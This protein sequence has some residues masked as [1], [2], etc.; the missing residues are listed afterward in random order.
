MILVV[1]AGAAAIP[2]FIF[3]LWH[4]L[5]EL[6]FLRPSVKNQAVTPKMPRRES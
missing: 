3:C 5:G 1:A 6:N 4:I 2:F